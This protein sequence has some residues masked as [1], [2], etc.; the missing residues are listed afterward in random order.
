MFLLPEVSPVQK[1][2]RT[3]DGKDLGASNRKF[4]GIALYMHKLFSFRSNYLGVLVE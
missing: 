1:S 3:P 4:S 2:V